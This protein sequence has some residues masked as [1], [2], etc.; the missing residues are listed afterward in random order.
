MGLGLA[1]LGLY[2][3]LSDSKPVG[4]WPDSMAEGQSKEHGTAGVQRRLVQDVILSSVELGSNC[5]TV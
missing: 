2:L 5:V 3:G 4:K 1:A